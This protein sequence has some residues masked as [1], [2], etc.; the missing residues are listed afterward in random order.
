MDWY[1]VRTKPHQEHSALAHW[2]RQG[3]Q[4]YVPQ[5]PAHVQSTALWPEDAATPLFPRYMF[6]RP[7]DGVVPR[8]ALG[9]GSAMGAGR[10]VEWAHQPVKVRK[11]LIDALRLLENAPQTS[12]PTAQDDARKALLHAPDTLSELQDLVSLTDGDSRV[13]ALMDLLSTPAHP[14]VFVE[15]RQQHRG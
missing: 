1:L 3:Y 12:P 9:S 5:V 2:E 13:M 14:D 8:G 15:R 10:V 4:C 6:V 7:G 11:V